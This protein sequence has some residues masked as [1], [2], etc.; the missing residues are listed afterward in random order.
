MKSLR[1]ITSWLASSDSSLPCFTRL[2]CS[3]LRDKAP[4]RGAMTRNTQSVNESKEGGKR[5]GQSESTIPMLNV[6]EAFNTGILLQL[7]GMRRTNECSTCRIYLTNSCQ[8]CSRCGSPKNSP[9]LHCYF[10]LGRPDYSDPPRAVS[11]KRHQIV[12]TGS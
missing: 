12:Q 3:L 9:C 7:T 2:L 1:E 10:E 4:R 8:R 11:I 6:A 5:M